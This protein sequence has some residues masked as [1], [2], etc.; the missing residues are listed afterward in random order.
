MMCKFYGYS[1]ECPYI[2]RDGNCKQA[3]CWYLK[4]ARQYQI[5]QTEKTEPI[6]QGIIIRLLMN[7]K[8]DTENELIEVR[9]ALLEKY[10]ENPSQKEIQWAENITK[11]ERLEELFRKYYG[12][13][14]MQTEWKIGESEITYNIKFMW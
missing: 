8:K 4:R 12:P 2:I 14:E 13:D 11:R 7:D 5:E 9:I 3:H 10:P 6:D 1:Y